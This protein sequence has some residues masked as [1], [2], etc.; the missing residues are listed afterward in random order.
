MFDDPYRRLFF[1]ANAADWDWARVQA[2]QGLSRTDVKLLDGLELSLGGRVLMAGAPPAEILPAIRARLGLTG[3]L[4]VAD[5]RVEALSAFSAYDAAWA[6]FLKTSTAALPLSDCC[7]DQVVC[8]SSFLELDDKFQSAL[9]FARVLAPGG[10]ATV[11]QAGP[12][13]PFGPPRP[14]AFGLQN[15]FIG[16]GFNRLDLEENEELQ[17]FQ[18]EKVKGYFLGRSG[19]A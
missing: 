6:V 8:W 16:A 7:L 15:I 3:Q 4:L 12:G 14:C 1:A 5:S 17:R 18:A 11:C 2:R 10:R 9:E 19:Q 13:S